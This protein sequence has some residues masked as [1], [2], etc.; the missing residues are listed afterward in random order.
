MPWPPTQLSAYGA[1][2][3]ATSF[4]G[5][6]G[7]M[8]SR[9]T[10]VILRDELLRHH[11][12]RGPERRPRGGQT[13]QR[14]TSQGRRA[15]TVPQAP[16]RANST[17]RPLCRRRQSS[18]RQFHGATRRSL[19]LTQK[20]QSARRLCSMGRC[21]TPRGSSQRYQCLGRHSY[22]SLRPVQQARV[23]PRWDCFLKGQS[24]NRQ[25]RPRRQGL[26]GG[27]LRRRSCSLRRVGRSAGTRGL[28]TNTNGFS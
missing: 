23:G 17:K 5:R 12:R 16:R 18:P 27:R 8:R 15:G 19:H 7:A 13:F 25:I 2:A 21:S 3:S 11:D 26:S 6:D 22:T 9:P 4:T 28:D 14:A 10:S 20:A 1:D 24:F